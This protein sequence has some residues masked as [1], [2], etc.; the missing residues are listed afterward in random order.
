[1]QAPGVFPRDRVTIVGVLN[2]T[3]DSFSD[4]GRFVGRTGAPEGETVDVE[5]AV[6]EARRLVEAGAHVLDLGGEST[7][8]GAEDVPVER[9]LA[10]TRVALERLAA[11]GLPV[12]LSID[13]RK[14]AVARAA[15]AAGA[16]VVNDVSGLR[17]DPALAEEVAAAGATLVLG[18]MR[19]TPATMQRDVD[20]DDVLAEVAGALEH[21]CERARRAGVP[22]ERLAVDPGL[23]FGKRLEDNLRLVAHAGWLRDRLGTPVMLGPSR[24]SFLGAL[25]GDPVGQREEATLAACAVAAFA[26][27]DALRV[28]EPAAVVRAARVGRALREARRKELS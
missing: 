22:H 4:G 27:A 25:T 19:G 23:G 3:P 10:R 9:E 26:G 5:A 28:H 8:P 11:A 17:H 13:T 18:H 7:R 14:A 20:Y 16:R 1:V 12:P 15:L 21:S 24:K 6:A 2:L